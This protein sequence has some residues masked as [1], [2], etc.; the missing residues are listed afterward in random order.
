MERIMSAIVVVSLCTLLLCSDMAHANT[1]VVGG[2]DGWSTNASSWSGKVFKTVFNYNPTY[3]N[4]VIVDEAGYNTCTAGEGSKTYQS[5]HDS[6]TLAK[7]TN[8][9]ICTFDGH[10][11]AKMKIAATAA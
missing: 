9:F 11:E 3:H 7:G 1:Y 10:C 6:I 8:Y 2:R 5:G 4:V